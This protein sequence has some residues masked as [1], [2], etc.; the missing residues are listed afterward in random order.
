MIGAAG[1]HVM[2]DG[3]RAIRRHLDV[4]TLE[5]RNAPSGGGANPGAPTGSSPTHHHPATFF[6]AKLTPSGVIAPLDATVAVGKPNKPIAPRPGMVVPPDPATGKVSFTLAANGNKLV[7]VG[8]LSHISNVSSVTLHDLAYPGYAYTDTVDSP[9]MVTIANY[10][11][12]IGQT[13]EV[14]LSPGNASGPVG[15]GIF[16]TV[17]KTGY[18]IGPLAGQPLHRLLADMGHHLIYVN[19]DTNNGVDPAAV[20]AGPG[21]FPFGEIRGM[22]VGK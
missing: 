2:A 10:P 17:I 7:V 22:V 12:A 13:V 8:K 9:T 18:L 1:R 21:N 15:S 16:N 6:V 20:P 14:L 5:G 19:V 4:V 3:R 11:G